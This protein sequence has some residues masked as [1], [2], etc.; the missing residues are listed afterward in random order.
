MLC[1][2]TLL[3]S[4]VGPSRPSPKSKTRR[5]PTATGSVVSVS[6]LKVPEERKG[7]GA[8]LQTKQDRLRAHPVLREFLK[9]GAGPSRPSRKPGTPAVRPRKATSFPLS[10]AQVSG[11]GTE[12]ARHFVDLDRL[13]TFCRKIDSSQPLPLATALLSGYKQIAPILSRDRRERCR[14]FLRRKVAN[15]FLHS[16]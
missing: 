13:A 8:R 7:C 12:I 1:A 2:P 10:S 4:G 3:W 16:R 9:S 15:G 14:V 6:S 5:R 11:A